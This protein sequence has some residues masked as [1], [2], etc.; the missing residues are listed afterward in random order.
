[1]PE[2]SSRGGVVKKYMIT[3][4][5]E[6]VKAILAAALIFVTSSLADLLIYGALAFYFGWNTVSKIDERAFD[7]ALYASLTVTMTVLSLVALREVWRR[8]TR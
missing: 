8:Y 7:F 5:W 3:Y 1:M 2:E 6:F 4:P